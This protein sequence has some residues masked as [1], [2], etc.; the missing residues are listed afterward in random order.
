MRGRF[1]KA[2]LVL[3]AFWSLRF[4][5]FGQDALFIP[6]S[7]RAMGNVGASLRAPEAF[8]FNPAAVASGKMLVGISYSQQF[9]LRELS[10]ASAF[11]IVPVWHSSFQV[12]YS[13]FGEASYRESQL[14]FGI[15]K[16]LGEHFFAGL[17]LHWFSLTMAENDSRPSLGSFSLGFHYCRDNYGFGLSAFNPLAQSMKKAG[18]EKKYPAIFR[19]G[20]HRLFNRKLLFTADLSWQNNK[21]LNSHWGL[22]CRFSAHFCARAGLETSN[23]TWSLGTGWTSGKLHA[24]LAYSYH[25][26]LG[27]SPSI[28]IYYC[29]P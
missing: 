7:V 12:G 4:T 28:T 26:Y 18:F 16:K 9:L 21:N 2:I 23:S 29:H 14:S 11:A 6:A 1:L 15:G 20:A 25:Q 19:F 13:Q 5:G 3:L 27:S 17:R 10:Q 24:D 22:E 8:E